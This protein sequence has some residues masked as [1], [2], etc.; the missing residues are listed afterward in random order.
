MDDAGTNAHKDCYELTRPAWFW[1]LL[2]RPH[3]LDVERL[4]G[5]IASLRSRQLCEAASDDE[6]KR[7]LECADRAREHKDLALGWDYVHRIRELFVQAVTDKQQLQVEAIELAQE[8]R[9]KID[10]GREDKDAWRRQSILEL[11]KPL[12]EP[13]KMRQSELKARLL[14]AM[15]LREGYFNTVH[16]K[17]ARWHYATNIVCCVMAGVVAL[18]V[19]MFLLGALGAVTN[20]KSNYGSNDEWLVILTVVLFGVLGASFSTLR[21]LT[22]GA[23]RYTE[24]RIPQQLLDLSSVLRR[25]FIGAGAALVAYLLALRI[26]DVQGTPYLYLAA[27]AAGFSDSLIEKGISGVQGKMS[28]GS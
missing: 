24:A 21:T 27:F 16:F 13:T 26:D 22:T 14:R 20:L 23:A 7:L 25:L 15:E 19:V 18:L 12:L 8:A 9:A 3:R 2:M 1:R 5:R 17:N 10:K 11:L 28:G 6:I 4:A